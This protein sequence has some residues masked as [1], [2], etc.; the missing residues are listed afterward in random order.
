MKLTRKEIERIAAD[1]VILSYRRRMIRFIIVYTFGLLLICFPV[2]MYTSIGIYIFFL[3][4]VL[5]I[6]F[7]IVVFNYKIMPK[8]RKMANKMFE[9][10]L[11]EENERPETGEI[12]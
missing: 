7:Y 8:A 11:R 6:F 5:V 12:S 3:G 4:L 10:M 1:R 2:S 9:E